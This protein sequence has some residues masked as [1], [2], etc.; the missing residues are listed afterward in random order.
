MSTLVEKFA[1]LELRP[2]YAE[3]ALYFHVLAGIWEQVWT[4]FIR[5]YSQIC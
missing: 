5:R 4:G 3:R 1:A 2:P